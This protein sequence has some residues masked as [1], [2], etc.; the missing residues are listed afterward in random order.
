MRRFVK[1][2]GL[3]TATIVLI[4]A[5][6]ILLVRAGVVGPPKVPP[7]AIASSVDRDSE[8]LERAFALP[9]ART[10]E[11]ELH[12][13]TNGSLCGPAS[14]VNVFRSLG[15]DVADES[16][17]LD[18]TGMCSLGF[19]AMGLTLDELAAVARANPRHEVTVLRDL[20]ADDFREHLRRSNDPDVRYVVNFSRKPIFGAGGGHHSPIAGYL[21]QEDLVLVLDVNADFRPWLVERD[22]LFAAVDTDDGGNKRGLLR[23]GAAAGANEARE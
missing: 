15:D 13:Q 17:V 6:L 5:V 3:A 12:W 23:I 11:R 19:C 18:G 14:L 8:R 9:A 16:A 4:V 22:R 20:S 2:L 21:E 1:W 10:Y 7:E